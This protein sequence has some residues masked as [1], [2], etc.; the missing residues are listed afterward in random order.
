MS[1]LPPE[2]VR[3]AIRLSLLPATPALGTPSSSGA[4]TPS[5]LLSY[6]SAHLP[7]PM[8]G[9]IRSPN[10]TANEDMDPF[11]ASFA[12]PVGLSLSK[13][14]QLRS[15]SL[16][17]HLFRALSQPLL[18]RSPVLP[19]LSSAMTF[20]STVEEDADLAAS[21]RT[22]RLGR[23]IEEGARGGAVDAKLV[24][25]RL[26]K[27]CREVREVELRGCGRVR[28]EDL[29]GFEDLRTVI[30]SS[31]LLAPSTS[32]E[33]SSPGLLDLTHLTLSSCHLT[34]HALPAALFP[35]L[36]ALELS[37]PR[38]SIASSPG[39]LASFVSAVAPQLRS[40]SLFDESASPFGALQQQGMDFNPLLDALPSFSS[41][42]V[43]FE[44]INT[45][46]LIYLPHF[47]SSARR[48][49]RTVS[50]SFGGSLDPATCRPRWIPLVDSLLRDTL[51]LVTAVLAPSSRG[52]DA[53]PLPMWVT[54]LEGV[55]RVLL[56]SRAWEVEGLRAMVLE[57]EKATAV[58]GKRL[59]VLPL[60]TFDEGTEEVESKEGKG[61]SGF[62][63]E[64]E[65]REKEER[66]EK[67]RSEGFW[68]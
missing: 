43:H 59:Q 26:A 18:F 53:P 58:E 20:L 48:S 28:A 35:S 31:C 42:L 1:L 7:T 40:F 9:T 3:E 4:S 57:L 54:D 50:M 32:Y 23:N 63:R 36:T 65:R 51:S 2:L 33:S 67:R 34:A 64:V 5:S 66:E 13:T 24:L 61:V 10:I 12:T 38:D 41:N 37:I 25:P 39:Q 22:V 30:L 29:L 68:W 11:D 8:N 52:W 16:T 44:T 14:A 6:G 49:L 19:T 21:V 27:V 47:P 55:E 17:S 56:P 45:H 46:P 15:L 60:L 62:W